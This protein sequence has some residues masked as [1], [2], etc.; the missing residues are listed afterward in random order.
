MLAD[1]H[2]DRAPVPTLAM[3]DPQAGVAEQTFWIDSSPLGKVERFVDKLTHEAVN[4]PGDGVRRRSRL[5]DDHPLTGDPGHFPNCLHAY[6]R[7]HVVK[8]K[9]ERR[10]LKTI[11]FEQQST[12]IHCAEVDFEVT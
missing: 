8:S 12:C 6:A 3:N 4:R 2:F 10:T 5:G 1:V 7:R 11:G 9:G